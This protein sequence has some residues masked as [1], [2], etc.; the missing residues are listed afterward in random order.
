MSGER[1]EKATPK[2]R[3]EAESKGQVARSQ[4]VNSAFVLAATFGALALTAPALRDQ[5]STL[6]RETMERV[7]R[8]DLTTETIGGLA[9]GWGRLTLTLCLPLLLAAVVAGVLANVVQNKPRLGG[10]GLK[11][12]FRRLNPLPGVK[13]MVGTQSLVELVKSFVKIGVI[14]SVAF[15][16]IWPQ[17]ETLVGVGYQEPSEIGAYTGTLIMRLCLFVV[18]ILVPLAVADLVY[19]RW[20]HEKSMRMTK[21]DVKQEARQQDVAPEIKGAIRRRARE[22]SRR[23]QLAEVPHADV[24]VTNPTHFAVA[25]RYGK[26]VTAP[27]VIAKGAD[28]L[29]A[30]IREIAAEHDVT[31][32]ENPPLARALY[33]QVEVGDEIPADYF[34]AVAEVLAF[35]FRTSRRTLSWV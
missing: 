7:A 17:L 6:F 15:L 5:L 25:L 14:G 35:V 26:E 12:D 32:V 2:R 24:I 11:P 23:R 8:P 10:A 30:R 4:E 9:A 1:T 18:A 34:G 31:I 29:A 22:L 21:D 3:G 16:V 27:R 13:R 20:H 28:L 19:Q 33:A